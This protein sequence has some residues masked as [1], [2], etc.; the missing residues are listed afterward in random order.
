MTNFALISVSS[1]F[2]YRFIM[3]ITCDYLWIKENKILQAHIQDLKMRLLSGGPDTN[4][5]SSKDG[6]TA[7]A[8]EAG[9][10]KVGESRPIF[11]TPKVHCGT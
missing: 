7:A 5:E 1:M 2:S 6:A 3:L 10:C 8:C 11:C 9:L 4:T